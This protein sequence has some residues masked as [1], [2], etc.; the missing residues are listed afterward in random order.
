MLASV[1]QLHVFIANS[2][3]AKTCCE[4]DV[5]YGALHADQPSTNA[6]KLNQPIEVRRQDFMRVVLEQS[7]RGAPF[8][9][10]AED[11]VVPRA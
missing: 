3:T 10:L 5:I 8:C 7:A 9:V 6:H 1:Q 2:V 4:N 11:D